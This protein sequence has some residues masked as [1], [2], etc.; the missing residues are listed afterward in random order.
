MSINHVGLEP[1]S[2]PINTLQYTGP[3]FGELDDTLQDT[4]NNWIEERGIDDVLGDY[5]VQKLHDVEQ[6]HYMNWLET[7]QSFISQE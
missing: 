4:F 3:S 6:E 5:L 1:D 7:T 2:G